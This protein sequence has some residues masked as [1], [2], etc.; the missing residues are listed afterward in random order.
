[1][2]EGHDVGGVWS[3]SVLCW[4]AKWDLGGLVWQIEAGFGDEGGVFSW[5]NWLRFQKRYTIDKPQIT[6]ARLL[7]KTAL[8]ILIP[9]PPGNNP[10]RPRTR[11][12]SKTSKRPK[13][14]KTPI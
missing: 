6:S 13:Q 14:N 1:M 12:T 5:L 2:E 9:I 8:L 7:Q 4:R 3:A 10:L 11:L